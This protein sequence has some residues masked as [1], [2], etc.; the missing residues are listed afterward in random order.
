MTTLEFA[1]QITD[2]ID[3]RPRRMDLDALLYEINIRTKGAPTKRIPKGG[4]ETYG[5]V[6]EMLGDTKTN[7][8][9][10]RKKISKQ[11]S[12]ISFYAQKVVELINT[13]PR[14]IN[15]DKLLYA[16]YVKASIADSRHAQ[17]EGRW[18]TH[19]EVMASMWKQINSILRKHY[20]HQASRR[21]SKNWLDKNMQ[22]S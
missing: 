17:R 12:A 19:E 9:N 6:M 11:S 4:W 5:D 8:S 15:L 16:I 21:K 14:Y 7:R 3:A 18:Y 1:Q 10:G 20:R 13:R 22:H 2:I